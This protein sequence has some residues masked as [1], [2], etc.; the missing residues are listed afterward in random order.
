MT[1]P[2]NEELR[3][4]FDLVIAAPADQRSATLDRECRGDAALKSRIEAM[5]AAAEDDVF[6]GSPTSDGALQATL[7]A[8]AADAEAIPREQAGQLVGRYKLLQQIGEGGFGTVWMAE[9][10]EPVKRRVALKII[11]LGMDTKQVIA[12]F[13][14]ERQALAMMEHPNIAH[15]LDAGSTDTGRPYF[16]MELVKGDP[17][18]EYCDRQNLST[19]ERLSIFQD[20]CHAVQHAHQKGII[21]RDIKPSNVLVTVADGRPIPKVIDFGI[22]KAT[23]RELTDKTLF[24]EFRQLIGT[25]EYMS[26]EQAERTGVDIDTRSDIYSMGVLMY[27]LLTGATPFDPQKLRSAAYGELQRI[28]R[29]EEPHRPS[30]RLSN[31]DVARH[32]RTDPA[33][34]S[35]ELRGDLDWIV[36]RCLEKDRTRRYETANGLALDIQRHLDDEPVLAGPPSMLYLAR[37][38]A[39]RNKVAAAAGLLVTAAILIGLA[40]SSVGLIR[41]QIANER[42]SQSI[43]K[44][45][46]ERERAEDAEELAEDRAGRLAT[47]LTETETAR[48]EAVTAKTE[49]E[50][51]AY[52]A[53][54]GAALAAVHDNE[55]RSA[56]RFLDQ[57]P[58]ALRGLEWDLVSSASDQSVATIGEPRGTLVHTAFSPD[59]TLMAQQVARGGE[60]N[61]IDTRTW[62]T[63]QTAPAHNKHNVGMVF[64][65][66]NRWLAVRYSGTQEVVIF[67]IENQ[68]RVV[69]HNAA[70]EWRQA[71]RFMAFSADSARCIVGGISAAEP[72]YDVRVW[73]LDPWQDLGPLVPGY[74][75]EIAASSPDGRWLVMGAQDGRPL[76]IF[77][78][79]TLELATEVPLPGA[80]ST[81]AIAFSD[82]GL[83]C[84][85]VESPNAR[86]RCYRTNDW[87]PI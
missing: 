15:V 42:L 62:E 31:I 7:A 63:V 78:A 87:E 24:T 29:E 25:P 65:P 54:L 49:A 81:F 19:A 61:I 16:V 73:Q 45:Q 35:R 85:T 12:R 40:V 21:H 77:V 58:E 6:L 11:K 27:E 20:V 53:S 64:S 13:E 41:A 10:R 67:D 60:I 39:A 79:E 47:A 69:P 22:A 76:H 38:F 33:A 52:T 75:P 5:V 3:R 37:K 46:A 50:R 66:D 72:D 71:M 86:I 44:E 18:T 14:A 26:P 74:T 68:G 4:L 2:S 23:N 59:G 43:V 9:Q 28:I 17:I 56:R 30:T 32:R 70:R 1:E 36:M 82:D 80:P 57:A 84:A 83:L 48:G 8:D 51:V 34:L 55:S